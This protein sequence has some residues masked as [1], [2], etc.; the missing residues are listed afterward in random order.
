MD[1]RDREEL[2]QPLHDAQVLLIVDPAELL[3]LQP[4]EL[5]RQLIDLV[6]DRIRRRQQRVP[7]GAL[8]IDLQDDALR[9]IAVSGN[10]FCTV[11]NGR[12]SSG[13]VLSPTHSA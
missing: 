9:A 6:Q 10:W 2:V 7:L 5:D 11:S 12:P 13:S 3:V 1:V 4:V 8:D